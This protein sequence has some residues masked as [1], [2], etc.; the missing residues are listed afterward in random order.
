MKPVRIGGVLLD[1]HKGAAVEIP[2]DP[3]ERWK[4]AAVALRPGR[5]GHRVIVQCA[6]QR[7]E[8]EIVSRA[9]RF[10]LAIDAAHCKAAGVS[11]GDP[12][13]LTLLPLD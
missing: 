3:A 6:D 12:I 13:E 1:G 11:I 4:T 5:R 2:F 8:S 10:F 7:F 9:R